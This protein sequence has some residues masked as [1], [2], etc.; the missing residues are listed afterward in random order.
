MT[1][2]NLILKL[3]F[4]HR[5]DILQQAEYQTNQHKIQRAN[6]NFQEENIIQTSFMH[7]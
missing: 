3:V 1:A 4:L 6:A 7:F 2:T 5:K